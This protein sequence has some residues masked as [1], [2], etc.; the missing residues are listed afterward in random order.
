[1]S[2]K[3]SIVMPTYNG[4]R[5]IRL[6]IESCLSQTYKDLELIVVDDGSAVDIGSIV[7]SYN[8]SRIKYFRHEQNLGLSRALNAGFSKASGSLLTWTSDDNKYEPDAIACM[9]DFLAKNPRIDMVFANY[10]LMGPDGGLLNAVKVG[11]PEFIYNGNYL[12]LCFL[13]RRKVYER[14]GG[15]D[16]DAFLVEDYEY[17]MKAHH[18]GCR[19]GTIDKCLYS[20]R[21]HGESLTGKHSREEVLRQ[22]QMARDKYIP[23]SLRYYQHGV[24]AFRKGDEREA[25]RLLWRS[26]VRY[27]FNLHAF[28]ILALIYF[29]E[30]LVDAVRRLK[31]KVL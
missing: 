15:Y 12:G 6:S 24:A 9:A 23:A 19:I 8:D 13:Y 14:I 30:K 7:R 18:A 16:P 3:V 28:R 27:P 20:F 1:M 5:Y 29:P 25:R 2:E 17:W 26:V 11:P 4:D 31:R 22:E 21:L 10:Y